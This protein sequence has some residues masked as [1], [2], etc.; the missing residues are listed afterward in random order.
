MARIDLIYLS[1]W[2]PCLLSALCVQKRR[3]PPSRRVARRSRAGSKSFILTRRPRR[4]ITGT[5]VWRSTLHGT[6]YPFIKRIRSGS[7]KKCRGRG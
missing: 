6:G 3:C 4:Y 2:S 7:R 5:S 1:L